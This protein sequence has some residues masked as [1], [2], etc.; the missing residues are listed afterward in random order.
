M[1]EWND[2]LSQ[3]FDM[4]NHTKEKW[5]NDKSDGYKELVARHFRLMFRREQ[6]K[7]MQTNLHQ[8]I[9]KLNNYKATNN[10][11]QMWKDI[12]KVSKNNVKVDIPEQE[13]IDHYEKMYEVELDEIDQ[14]EERYVKAAVDE[15]NSKKEKIFITDE[16]IREIIKL[17]PN[18]KATGHMGI[19]NE[20]YKHAPTWIEQV[21]KYLVSNAINHNIVLE[22][23]NI[24]VVFTIIKDSEQPSNQM[25]NTRGITV[26]DTIATILENY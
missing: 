20:Q 26:S 2:H 14:E 24:G 7:F 18:N 19:S 4:H 21:V 5:R 25:S 23:Y 15:V 9:D 6:R 8:Q 17:L 10:I 3:L 13:Q 12:K 1:R 11:N 16:Q 22:D